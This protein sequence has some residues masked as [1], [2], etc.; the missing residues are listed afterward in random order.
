MST[1]ALQEYVN[2][3]GCIGKNICDGCH[4]IIYDDILGENCIPNM[5][6]LSGMEVATALLNPDK[7]PDIMEQVFSLLLI[8]GTYGTHRPSRIRNKK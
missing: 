3:D 5:L 7:Y 8:G 2:N 6:D 1:E 4:M